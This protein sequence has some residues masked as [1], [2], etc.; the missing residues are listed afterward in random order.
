MYNIILVVIYRLTKIVYF[1]LYNKAIDTELFSKVLF[2][3]VI[4]YYR[5]L[6]EVVLD[7]DKLFISKF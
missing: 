7:R 4:S 6:A 5:T 3:I 1:I 2:K